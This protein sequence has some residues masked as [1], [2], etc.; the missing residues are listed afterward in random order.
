MR[1]FHRSIAVL[2]I[3]AV[4]AAVASAQVGPTGQ[5]QFACAANVT[6]TPSLRGEGF[7]EL[8]GDITITCTGGAAMASGN[9]IPLVNITV[10]Y[11]STVTNRLLPTTSPQASNLTSDALLLID[12]PGAGLPGYGSSLPQ[13]LCTSPLTGCSAVAGIVAIGPYAGAIAAMVPGTS[14][15]APN[16]YQ[17]VADG[18]SM[19]FFGVPVLP[20]TATGSRVFRITGVRVNAQALVAA[21][22]SGLAP[23]QAA[24]SI[25][26]TSF[27]ISNSQPVVGYVANGL[28]ASASG[29]VNLS[30]CTAQTKTSISTLTFAE[31]FGSAFKTRVFAQTNTLYNGQINN[32]V[33]NSPGGIYNSE[34]GLVFPINGTQTAGLTD[35][36][37]RLKATFNNIPP[38]TRVFVSTANVLN[39]ASPVSVPS[40]IGGSQGN[41]SFSGSYVGYAQLVGSET[42]SD[43]NAALGGIFPAVTPTDFGPNNGAVPIAEV[44]IVNGTGNAVWEVVNT[45]PNTNE[46][47]N[48]GVYASYAAT[49]ASQNP[50]P[51]GT[52]TVTLSFAA[53]ANSGVAADSGSPLPRFSFSASPAIPAFTIQPCTACASMIDPYS[54]PSLP[55]SPQSGI[56]VNVFANPGCGWTAASNDSWLSLIYG[57]SG[58]GNS[59]VQFSAQANS[60]SLVRT[61]SLTIAGQTMVITQRA[62]E[63]LVSNA[64]NSFFAPEQTVSPGEAIQLVSPVQF[65]PIPA[66]YPANTTPGSILP[67]SLGGT[68]VLFDG[69]P[70]PLLWTSNTSA[71]AIVPHTVSGNVSTLIEVEYNGVRLDSANLAVAA[72]TP[73]IYLGTPPQIFLL[74]PGGMNYATDPVLPGMSVA[75]ILTGAGLTNPAGTDGRIYSSSDNLPNLVQP[76]TVSVGGFPAAVVSATVAPAGDSQWAA[77]AYEVRFIVPPGAPAGTAVPFRATVGGV[78]APAQG[79]MNISAS[80]CSFALDQSSYPASASGGANSVNLTTTTGCYWSAFSNVNWIAVTPAGG[81]TDSGT[82][83]FNVAA[84]NSLQPR[85]GTLTIGGRTLTINQAAA[86]AVTCAT[87]PAGVVWYQSVNYVS[88]ANSASDLVLVGNMPVDKWNL[89]GTVALPAVPN[90]QFCGLIPIAPGYLATAY[91]PTAAERGGDFSPFSGILLDPASAHQL[92]GVTV[93]DPFAGGII[94]LSRMPATMAWRLSSY[95]TCT[96]NVTPGGDSSV[97]PAA[98]A[99]RGVTMTADNGT[100]GWAATS[101]ASWL[102]FPAGNTGVGSQTVSYS[103]AANTTAVSRSA[104]ITVAGQTF[105]VTQAG[106][107]QALRFV[108][109]TPCRIADTRNATGP[110]GGPSISGGTSRDFTIPSSACSIPSTAQAYSLN[111]AVVPTTTLGYLTLYPAGQSRPL[112]STL[113]SLDGRIKSNAAIVPAG[114]GGAISVFASDTTQAILDINGYFVP[115]TD[116]NGLAFYPI[117]PCRITDT[118]TATAPLGGPALVGGQNRTLPIQSSTCNLPATAQAYSLNFA[119]VPGGSSLGY[120]TAWPTGQSRPVAASLNALTGAVTANAAIVP[121][122]TNGSIDVFASNNTNLVIDINGYFAPMGTGGLSLYGVTPCRVLDTRQPSGSPPITSRDVAVSASACGIPATAQADVMSVTVVPQGTPAYLGYLT[123]WPQ[124]QTR[125]VVSTLNALDGAITSNL[126]IVP[127]TNGSISAFAS[128]ATHLIIDISGYF[129]P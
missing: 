115:A 71:S 62:P 68:R 109:I 90:Q 35:F 17:G 66:A 52:T 22:M 67:T 38:G 10:F 95:A 122:G 8:T 5:S 12:E 117:T 18:N 54:V 102:T 113:N 118:R 47:F 92:N 7:T 60:S 87:P 6:V 58:S 59:S 45:N 65:G 31:N 27:S 46:T 105:T 76:V 86:S 129:A 25:S 81:G 111:V 15:P 127:T 89:L 77:G 64:A 40:P 33:Q 41:G 79:T 3:F 83:S 20:P 69:N 72:V 63:L 11:N 70:A 116:P 56:N 107:S 61:G 106:A 1:Y 51:T 19:T 100:C 49:S 114:T 121:A 84:S 74:L 50:P 104:S 88:G 32:P 119:A 23:A 93:L 55:P 21:S 123:L 34:S 112:A 36:G 57:S 30:Q 9:Y 75:A 29:A 53:T 110:F 48:F 2:G 96:V 94:P 14:T 128:N 16:V 98:G 80:S 82:V 24:I 42:A 126:A 37:T 85:I 108:P 43:G 13:T 103:V 120:L 28:S 91:V 99:S 44:Q 39:N 97:V 124:G 101:S 73:G 4:F 125:P 26:P 78:A